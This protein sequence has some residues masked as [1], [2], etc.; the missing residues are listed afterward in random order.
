MVMNPWLCA[1]GAVLMVT[2]LGTSFFMGYKYATDQ[3]QDAMLTQ[4]Q[5]IALAVQE[6]T[7]AQMDAARVTGQLVEARRARDAKINQQVMEAIT[8]L[9]TVTTQACEI[10]PEALRL[11]NQA[12]RK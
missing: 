1:A 12:G 7:R 10:T 8:G 2:L 11:L 5:A 6:K 3:Y 4:Q 9:P